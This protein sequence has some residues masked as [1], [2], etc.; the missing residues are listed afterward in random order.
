MEVLFI[1]LKSMSTIIP[2]I[3]IIGSLVCMGIIVV[4]KFP[5]LSILEVGTV[6]S[7]REA[8]IKRDI[9]IKRLKRLRA[10]RVIKLI[11]SVTPLLG[12]FGK[13]IK[14]WFLSFYQKILDVE[15][16]HRKLKSVETDETPLK[17]ESLLEEADELVKK[18]NLK[19]AEKKYLE[20]IAL[21]YKNTSSYEGL[22][23]IYLK[24]REYKEA[25]ETFEF[26]LKLDPNRPDIY[27]DLSEAF[28]SLGDGEKAIENLNKALEFEPNNPKYLD[29]LIEVGIMSKNYKVCKRA[30]DKLKE[31]NPENQKIEEF[32]VRL[33]GIGRN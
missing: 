32:E 17:L 20:V 19:E 27:F 28:V 31:V 23:E 26:V 30:L 9:L 1:I 29:F 8:K 5:Q 4:R 3:L 12:P 11:Q 18:D 15:K 25:K 22:G 14:K 6:K 24:R 7:E 16:R 10:E 13:R 2:I 33:K 21:D